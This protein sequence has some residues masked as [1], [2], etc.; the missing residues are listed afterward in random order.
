MTRLKRVLR[1]SASH[2][3][4]TVLLLLLFF[5]LVQVATIPWF[6]V[7]RLKDE[8][9]KETALMR[10]RIDEAEAKGKPLVI[11]QSWVPL[12]RLPKHL[13]DAIVV[14]EDGT[15]YEHNGFDWF[16]V[17]ESLEKN[18][19]ERRAARGGSTITQQLAKN[20]Y[21]STSKDP[22]RKAREIAITMLLEQHL[23]KQRIL[24]LYVN[25]IEWGD[26]IFGVDAAARK[27]F[28]RPAS[29]LTLEQSLRLAAVIP[30]PLRHRPDVDSRYVVRRSDIIRR[31]MQGR[32]FVPFPEE[33]EAEERAA[34]VG[35]PQALPDTIQTG[36]G[37]AEPANGGAGPTDRTSE[38]PQ[39]TPSPE[40]ADSA[41]GG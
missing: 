28:G 15:F 30:S 18:I 35:A 33:V 36:S 17:R 21:L 24:E 40:K 23:S 12:S 20:L 26:G 32:R 13:T 8:N 7:P 14:A 41:G 4:L 27:Y 3:L 34:E 1:W 10:Q 16:E 25:L 6:A 2:K 22:L 5:F 9:P 31:R 38:P 39:G 19:K 37:D 29:A 11:R